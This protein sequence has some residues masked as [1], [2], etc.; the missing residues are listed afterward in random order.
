MWRIENSEKMRN[1]FDYEMNML[2]SV[3]IDKNRKTCSKPQ[4]ME[5]TL[6]R[7]PLYTT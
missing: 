1:N 6:F 5:C 7:A 2:A 4:K 3:N